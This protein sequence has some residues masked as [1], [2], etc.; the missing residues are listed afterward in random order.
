MKLSEVLLK[1]SGFKSVT[2]PIIREMVL[3]T[4]NRGNH[5]DERTNWKSFPAP[6]NNDFLIAPFG[7]G[8]YDL[9]NKQAGQLILFGSSEN[10]AHRMSRL[11]PEPL[12]CGTRNNI[13]K[14]K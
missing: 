1:L 12:G 5:M 13:K 6:C 3:G 2:T 7:P 8:V 4:C 11:L 14:R 10:C 9:R